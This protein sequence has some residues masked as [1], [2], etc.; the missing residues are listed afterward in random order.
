[1]SLTLRGRCSEIHDSPIIR[2][3]DPIL[4]ASDLDQAMLFG[5]FFFGG[6]NWGHFKWDLS[7]ILNSMVYLPTKL[8]LKMN[9]M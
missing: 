2:F 4:Q 1:M 8:P 5:R 7:Q 3:Q 9:Q 6:P